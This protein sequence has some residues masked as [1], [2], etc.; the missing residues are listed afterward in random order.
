MSNEKP[1]LVV[2]RFRIW[3]DSD[4][5]WRSNALHIDRDKEVLVLSSGPIGFFGKWGPKGWV[6]EGRVFEQLTSEEVNML[7]HVGTRLPPGFEALAEQTT[8]DLKKRVD[9][10]GSDELKK[11]F[12]KIFKLCRKEV[13]RIQRPRLLR[14]LPI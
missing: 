14:W 4:S 8:L 5:G 6:I 9:K 1:G 13:R 2:G 11:I 7:R 12:E 10:F 3:P